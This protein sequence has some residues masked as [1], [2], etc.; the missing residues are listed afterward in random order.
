LVAMWVVISFSV[1]SE[2][3]VGIE[4]VFPKDGN[5]PSQKIIK[6]IAKRDF[7]PTATIHLRMIVEGVENERT[8]CC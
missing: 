7:S 5:R 8:K 4:K 6:Q 3:A 2:S 1:G